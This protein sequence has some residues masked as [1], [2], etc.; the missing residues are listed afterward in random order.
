MP[1]PHQP[2]DQ[3]GEMMSSRGLFLIVLVST[4]NTLE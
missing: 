2:C 3:A 4:A 1:A